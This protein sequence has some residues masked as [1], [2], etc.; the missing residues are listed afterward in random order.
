MK[1]ITFSELAPSIS[2]VVVT[3]NR[4]QYLQNLLRS[5]NNLNG[6]LSKIE[7]VIAD[8]GSTDGTSPKTLELV[9]KEVSA[10]FVTETKIGINFVRNRG[11][12]AASGELIAFVDDDAVLDP[13]WLIGLRK[14][15]K[16]FSKIYPIAIYGGRTVLRWEAPC[17]DWL[18]DDLKPWL[19]CSDYGSKNM[20]S[21]N[22]SFNIV[23][24]NFAISRENLEKIGGFNTA[25]AAYGRDERWIEEMIHEMG[26]VT[27]Y[28]GEALVF[29]SVHPERCTKEWFKNRFYREGVAVRLYEKAK[30][31]YI[32]RYYFF[33]SKGIL[34]LTLKALTSSLLGRITNR[35]DFN[36]A[37]KIQF[38]KGYYSTLFSIKL[39]YL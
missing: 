32:S 10:H 3:K 39:K 4:L 27:V 23:G 19:S 16:E 33:I 7:I 34:K 21:V 17:P 26:G 13:D 5:F 30:S 29:H 38:L 36:N 2:I 15:Y 35:S 14:T 37:L 9:R 24:A 25:L 6:D 28:A 20:V 11:W 12:R 18:T 1:D 31:I 8:N 22:S